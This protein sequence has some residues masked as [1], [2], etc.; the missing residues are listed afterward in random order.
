MISPRPISVESPDAD[1]RR[2]CGESD[3]RSASSTRQAV[4]LSYVIPN[5]V[6]VSQR[7][8][9]EI[10][11]YREVLNA[12]HSHPADITLT[13]NAVL[14]LHRDLFQFAPG[15]GGRWKSMDNGILED[16][17]DGTSVVRF[18]PLPAHLTAG[19]IDR[20]H[21]E[22]ATL[23]AGTVEPL[24]LIPAYVLDFLCIHPF[25]DGNAPPDMRR[26]RQKPATSRCKLR[27]GNRPR[28]HAARAVL[29]VVS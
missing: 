23:D 7:L 9:Q 24:L 11:G 4:G 15:G 2:P 10:A 13:P 8:K 1:R 6:S 16:R 27:W 25:A 20:L 19:A 28:K 21:I 26:G 3:A 22:R 18:K 14:Q 5:T 17:P 12:I 29:C